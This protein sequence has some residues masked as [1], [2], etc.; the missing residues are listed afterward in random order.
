[1]PGTSHANGGGSSPDGETSSSSH[2]I[3]LRTVNNGQVTSINQNGSFLAL[4]P[5]VEAWY[6]P[7]SQS[8]IGS[9]RPPMPQHA[10][11][12]IYDVT[13]RLFGLKSDYDESLYTTTI[14]KSHPNYQPRLPASDRPKRA[15]AAEP[16]DP[17]VP[18][19]KP[20]PGDAASAV[21]ETQ[22]DNQ[23]G[24][25]EEH[26]NGDQQGTEEEDKNGANPEAQEIQ[27]HEHDEDGNGKET[28]EN[29]EQAEG[30]TKQTG[31]SAEQA[32]ET[33]DQTE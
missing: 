33:P 8:A 17:P 12:D 24:A 31:E 32:R 9:K 30:A 10:P 16:V 6:T 2:H 27:P 28:Q 19:P 7:V 13:E 14:D 21:T 4:G 25:K 23:Q 18:E 3:A 5:D 15:P 11:W 20:A 22:G 1:M 26:K 29:A